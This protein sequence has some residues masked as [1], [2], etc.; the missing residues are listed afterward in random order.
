MGSMRSEKTLVHGHLPT[1]N[2]YRIDLMYISNANRITQ[3][4]TELGEG[5]SLTPH[6][7]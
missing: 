2:E 6:L 4:E 7:E 1:F 3:K 5:E